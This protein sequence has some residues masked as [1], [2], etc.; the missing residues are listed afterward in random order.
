MEKNKPETTIRVGGGVKAAI[1]KNETDN[2]V[3]YS[4]TIARTYKDGNGDLQDTASFSRS[5]LLFVAKA[6]DK[7]FDF[8]VEDRD[9]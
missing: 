3:R 9:D 5:D 6:A 2:G 1:W 8:L 7:A 4:V